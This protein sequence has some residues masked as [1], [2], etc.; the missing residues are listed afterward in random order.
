[1]ADDNQLKIIDFGFSAKPKG[2][3]ASLL[4][5]KSMCGTPLYMAPEVISCKPYLGILLY[6]E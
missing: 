3:M 1:M 2:G 5:D 4:R 6:L